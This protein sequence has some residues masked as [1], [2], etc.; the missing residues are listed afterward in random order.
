[1]SNKTYIRKIQLDIMFRGWEGTDLETIGIRKEDVINVQVM[2]GNNFGGV[3]LFYWS[4]E[5]Q[6]IEN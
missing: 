5:P 4:E 2:E 6:T 1:M 3:Y